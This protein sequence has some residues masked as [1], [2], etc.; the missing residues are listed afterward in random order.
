MAG[1]RKK[2][3]EQTGAD[4]R[5]SAIDLRGPGGANPGAHERDMKAR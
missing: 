4:V 3:D 2:N 5:P 1:R